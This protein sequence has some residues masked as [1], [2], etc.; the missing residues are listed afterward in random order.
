MCDLLFTFHDSHS[1]IRFR[2]SCKNLS[3]RVKSNLG[4]IGRR[5]IHC[6]RM[7]SATLTFLRIPVLAPWTSS[8]MLSM[9][10]TRDSKAR[11]EITEGTVRRYNENYKPSDSIDIT[12][13]PLRSGLGSGRRRRNFWMFSR[14]TGNCQTPSALYVLPAPFLLSDDKSDRFLDSCTKKS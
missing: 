4:Q 13:G 6:S 8:G 12:V 9:L 11:N 14:P 10:W 2:F 7:T 3:I 1:V 5:S